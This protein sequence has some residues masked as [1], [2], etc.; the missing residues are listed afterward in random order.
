MLFKI[1]KVVKEGNQNGYDVVAL[2]LMK[3]WVV[4]CKR[5]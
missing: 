5:H 4:L 3:N 2:V 1:E